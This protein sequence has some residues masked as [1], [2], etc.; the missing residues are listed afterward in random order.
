MDKE[1]SWSELKDKEI[2]SILDGDTELIQ[3][4]NLTLNM[5]HLTAKDIV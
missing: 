4:D 3:S 2:V 5:P 1:N